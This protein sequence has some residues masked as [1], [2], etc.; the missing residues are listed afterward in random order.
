MFL[1]KQTCKRAHNVYKFM[2]VKRSLL[3]ADEHTETF[4]PYFSIFFFGTEMFLA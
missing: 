4:V 3:P 1:Q 2:N